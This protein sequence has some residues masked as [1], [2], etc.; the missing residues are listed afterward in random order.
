MFILFG[1]THYKIKGRQ[2][3]NILKELK[4]GD[5]LLRHYD[6]YLSGL[7]IPGYYDHAAMFI[8]KENE[9]ENNEVYA[10]PEYVVHAISEGVVKEDILCFIRCDGV[11]ILRPRLKNQ[12][13]AAQDAV[14]R[15][16][17][18]VGREYDA[19]YDRKTMYRL[20][21]SEL[22]VYCYRVYEGELNFVVRKKGL[23]K[24]KYIPEDFYRK[25]NFEI[26]YD[27]REDTDTTPETNMKK[28]VSKAME[29]EKRI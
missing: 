19:D 11:A 22:V 25:S 29:E 9:N 21:C 7:V 12:Q 10:I 16:K 26:V 4:P 27:S 14:G 13:E 20:Y 3:R 5:V 24:G 8:G 23:S 6:K 28:R 2:T 15:A 18:A 1:D 17:K